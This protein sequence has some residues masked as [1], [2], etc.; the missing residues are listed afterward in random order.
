MRR[1]GLAAVL[2]ALSLVPAHATRPRQDRPAAPPVA[3]PAPVLDPG[4]MCRQAILAA[5]AEHALPTALLQTIA[6]VES[7]RTDPR[8]GQ[9]TPWP[10]TINAEGQGRFFATKAEAVAAVQE[11]HARNVRVIDVGC[12]QVNLHHHPH[13]FSSIEN[14]FDPVL[15]AR[16]AGLFLRRLYA[17]RGDWAVAATSYHSATPEFAEAYRQRLAA[18]GLALVGGGTPE[19]LRRL[20]VA[21]AGMTGRPMQ[22]RFGGRTMQVW[23]FGGRVQAWPSA[24][25]LG[26]WSTAGG[27]NSLTLATG[28][29]GPGSMPLRGIRAPVL[30]PGP[31]LPPAPVIGAAAPRQFGITELADAM[32]TE[33]P[34]SRR[35]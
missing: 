23:V 3:A 22:V 5:E 13:A 12:L 9:P 28:F 34:L 25:P 21:Q 26:A 18:A 31:R 19:A 16:Y 32:L 6:R 11:L 1:L 15:N 10:W 4:Q 20:A 24:P 7:G 29:G 33:R 35:R 27:P 30:P 8:T 17:A 14:A 2:T